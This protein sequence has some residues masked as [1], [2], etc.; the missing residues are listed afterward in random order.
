MVSARRPAGYHAVPMVRTVVRKTQRF[1]LYNAIRLTR[2]RGKSERVARGF[3]L[4]LVVNFFPTFG[5][6]MLISGFVARALGGNFVAGVV[7]GAMLNFFWPALFYLNIHSGQLLFRPPVAV[8][9]LEDVTEKTM[10]A[11]LW[12]RTFTAGAIFNAAVVGLA[13]YLLLLLLYEKT[14]P[15]A[16]A[17]FRRHAEEHHRR[18]RRPA[19]RRR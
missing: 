1:F 4:G 2:I 16:L 12:G 19:E 8:E 13:A 17:Y 14:R 11:L 10:D 5:F 6:G 18:F 7:G 9:H 15:A 3:A